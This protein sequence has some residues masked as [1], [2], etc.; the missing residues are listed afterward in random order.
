MFLDSISTTQDLPSKMNAVRLAGN[1]SQEIFATAYSW[2]ERCLRDHATCKKQISTKRP[3]PSRLVYLGN[4]KTLS[5]RIVETKTLKAHVTYATLSH[6]WGKEKYTCLTRQNLD[7][8]K[9]KVPDSAISNTFREAMQLAK[10]FDLYY[11]W[12]DS[13]CIMQKDFNDWA[14]ESLR[15]SDVY[16]GA[17]CNLAASA[18]KDGRAGLYSPRSGHLSTPCKIT[19]PRAD[20]IE[21]KQTAYLVDQ[22]LW[23]SRVTNSP[24]GKRAWVIQERYLAQRMVHFGY[25]QVF[26]ECREVKSCQIFPDLLPSEIQTYSTGKEDYDFHQP[27]PKV[28][29]DTMDLVRFWD[30]A[31]LSQQQALNIWDA[32]VFE[33]TNA[34]LT[35]DT[36]KL[37]AISGLA[38]SIMGVMKC[39]YLAG[40]W[41]YELHKQLLWSVVDLFGATRPIPYIAPTWS[42]ASI[43][44]QIIPRPEELDEWDESNGRKLV[45]INEANIEGVTNDP[46]GQSKSG[47]LTVVGPLAMSTIGIPA[48]SDETR[49]LMRHQPF[50]MSQQ[51]TPL[52]YLDTRNFKEGELVY[53]LPILERFAEKAEP[54][55]KRVK[56]LILGLVL[57][58][59]KVSLFQRVGI[60]RVEE[61]D[62]YREGG[63]EQFWAQCRASA[64]QNGTKTT[65]QLT[66]TMNDGQGIPHYTI[67]IE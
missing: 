23:L 51:L 18:A 37:V 60:F 31:D 55:V 21:G 61:A 47:H 19:I 3:L 8:M 62:Y 39:R 14:T 63:I 9:K 12:I 25:D 54:F 59:N 30:R 32:F 41:N 35:D 44:G 53:C 22:E 57:I 17:I 26:W 40:L 58:R 43:C 56:P 4:T 64:G 42:W 67:R 7:D 15:M 50:D 11:I 20:M 33:Y 66:Q 28:V 24:L 52:V 2:Y 10:H 6:C 13:L 1:D 34:N 36:D 46:M 65:N 38:K 29:N 27:P 49:V 16:K 5:P 45:E 48:I